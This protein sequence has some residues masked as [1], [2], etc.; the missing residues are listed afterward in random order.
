MCINCV[1]S[2]MSNPTNKLVV[3]TSVILAISLLVLFIVRRKSLTNSKKLGI[4]YSFAFFSIFPFVFYTYA[5]TCQTIFLSCNAIQSIIYSALVTII[6]SAVISFLFVPFIYGFS[7]R[8]TLIGKN[9]AFFHRV[10]KYADKLGIKTPR[11]Y[12]IDK[13]EPVAFSV[14]H[15]NPSIFFTVGLIEL[16]NAKEF[17][18]VLLHELGH[19]KQKSSF[20]KFTNSLFKLF[21]PLSHF[22]ALHQELNQEE[23]DADKAAIEFQRTDNYLISAKQK[24]ADY[25]RKKEQ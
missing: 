19:I 12:I 25:H 20:L 22:N 10:E 16:L 23:R 5:R 1:M 2:F 17:E 11:L 14:S 4:I 18:A 21:F 24:L 7:S 6:F 9:S 8:N 15:I 13:A 3:V